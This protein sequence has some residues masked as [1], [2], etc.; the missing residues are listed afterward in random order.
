MLMYSWPLKHGFESSRR[1]GGCGN[2][3]QASGEAVDLRACLLL[4]GHGVSAVRRGRH[5]PTSGR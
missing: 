3:S 1:N 4:P 5:V 2:G